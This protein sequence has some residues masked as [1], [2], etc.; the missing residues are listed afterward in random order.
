MRIDQRTVASLVLPEGKTDIICFDED[1]TGFGFRIRLSGG[2]E[3]RSFVCQYRWGGKSKRLNLGKANVLMAAEARKLAKSALAKVQLGIDPGQEKR[4]RHGADAVTFSWLAQQFVDAKRSE[5]TVK[6]TTIYG[7]DRVLLKA[8]YF[9]S[10]HS[11]SISQITR[12]DIAARL[13]IITKTNGPVMSNRSRAALTNM[14]SWAV[15]AGLAE[16]NPCIGLGKPPKEKSREHVLTDQELAA[17]WKACGDDEHG[18]IIRLLILTACRR[19]EVGGMRWS[20]LEKGTWTIP[21]SRTKN[22][23]AHVLPITPMMQDIIEPI[24]DEGQPRV[25]RVVGRDPLFGERAEVGYTKWSHDKPALDE[26]LGDAV[27]PWTVHDLRRSTATKMADLGVQPHIIEQILNHQSGHKGGVAGI[28][29]R[30]SYKNEVRAAMLMWS[31]HIQSLVS[32]TERKVVPFG[33]PEAA[34]QS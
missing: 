21:G 27:Q 18:R 14:F 26:R 31:D 30:S 6:P 22:K 33:R 13:L 29:N 9:K 28:Y 11:V 2:R 34:V 4:Q 8:D 19:Q 1:L 7:L 15:G 5:G 16:E 23:K 17:V 32:G 3:L 10:L 24:D 20:E 25:P 12:R